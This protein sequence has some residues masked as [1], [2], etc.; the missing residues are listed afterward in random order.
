[1][2]LGDRIKERRVELKWNQD[3]LATKAGISKGFLS[4]L[5]NGKRSIRADTL[6]KIA[7]VLGYT[8]DYLVL[9]EG[10]PKSDNINS[11]IQIPPK[12]SELA[13]VEKLSFS[14][15]VALLQIRHQI[16]AHRS[17]TKTENL[18]DFDW[19]GLYNSVKDFIK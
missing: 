19:V 3:D 5:E 2:S 4:D 8:L 17:N 10:E 1:M 15:V 14:E 9:G 16:V 11:E 6:S 13:A 12:L 7:R 18:D